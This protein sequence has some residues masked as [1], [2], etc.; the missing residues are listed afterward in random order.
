M[1][2]PPHR[3]SPL[4]TPPHR[5]RRQRVPKPPPPGTALRTQ[6]C[7]AVTLGIVLPARLIRLQRFTKGGEYAMIF[8]TGPHWHLAASEP[9]GR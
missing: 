7:R 2:L 6:P 4:L 8:P 9:G 3:C 5:D 1:S